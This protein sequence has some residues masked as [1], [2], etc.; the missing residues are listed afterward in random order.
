MKN[1]KIQMRLGWVR[2]YEK[3]GDAGYVCRRC[4]ISRPTLRKWHKRYQ[5]LGIDGLQD[6]SKKPKN[7][8][9]RKI[10]DQQEKWIIDLRA[11]MNLGARR[12]QN[13]LV[14]QHNLHLSLSTIQKV[15]DRHEVKPLIKPKRQKKYKKYQKEVPGERVQVD[16]CKIRPG[17]YQFTAVDDCTRYLVAEIYPRRTAANTLLFLDKLVEEM[18]F[19]I[20]R[21]QT[22][23]GTEFFAYKVQERLFE[24]GIKFRPNRPGAPHLNGKVERVQKTMLIEFYATANLDD[25]Q[26]SLRLAEWQ[27]FYNWFR[28][29]GSIGTTPNEKLSLLSDKTPYWEDAEKLFDPNKE[30]IRSQSYLKDSAIH[31][32]KRCL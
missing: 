17:M 19:P 9:K 18:H 7:S 10:F 32:L 26:L 28:V 20:Q 22:D 4:G 15:L 8:P 29:H 23:R 1:R 13:E 24:W 3:T 16:T 30:Y 2:L 6:Q 11:E 31:K 12:I 27:H 5:E 14:Y 21:I 25:P